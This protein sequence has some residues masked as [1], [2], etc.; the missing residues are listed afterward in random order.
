MPM[1]RRWMIPPSIITIPSRRRRTTISIRRI[2]MLRMLRMRRWARTAGGWTLTIFPIV[3]RASVSMAF[4]R[5]I[6]TVRSS[7]NSWPIGR[8]ASGWWGS[9]VI[10]RRCSIVGRG[11]AAG[12]L[13]PVLLVAGVLHDST[14]DPMHP[15]DLQ[16][17]LLRR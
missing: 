8:L 4:G 14:V 1:R 9:P 5:A 7:K 6:G 11:W 2:I 13:W 17:F 10:R 12:V 15:D 3:G 16:R